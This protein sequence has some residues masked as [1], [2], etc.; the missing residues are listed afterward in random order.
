MY[1]GNFRL[2][3]DFVPNLNPPANYVE[4]PWLFVPP[5]PPPYLMQDLILASQAGP[6][7]PWYDGSYNV[8]SPGWVGPGYQ[9]MT[10]NWQHHYYQPH[11]QYNR[12][13]SSGPIRSGYQGTRGLHLADAPTTFQFV[14]ESTAM[15]ADGDRRT[16]TNPA[17]A[18]MGATN[19]PGVRKV[20]EPRQRTH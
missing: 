7:I 12:P 5:A 14:H 2:T 11:W 9:G 8:P 18:R 16:G 6:I 3:M 15:I 10:A 19:N 20:G 13:P 17:K 1:T 4:H